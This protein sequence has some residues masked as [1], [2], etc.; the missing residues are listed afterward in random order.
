MRTYHNTG[1]RWYFRIPETWRGAVTGVR[2]SS[3]GQATVVFSLRESGEPVLR[4]NV[5]TGSDQELKAVQGEQF[6]LSR[7]SERIYT[8][9]LL[10]A[11]DTWKHGITV[12]EVR[13]AFS[14]ITAEWVSGEN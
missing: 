6:L 9:E 10:T 5:Y 11:N 14:L 8:G 13:A 12:D 4:I 7:Q 1:D 3:T 2:T